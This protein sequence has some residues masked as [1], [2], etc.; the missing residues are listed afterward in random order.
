M[1]EEYQEC[2]IKKKGQKEMN[3]NEKEMKKKKK[4]EKGVCKEN[5]T[6]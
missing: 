1:K 2:R 3:E 5:S 6:Q 4:S